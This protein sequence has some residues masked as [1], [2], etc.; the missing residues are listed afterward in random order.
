VD[1][2]G[3]TEPLALLRAPSLSVSRLLG[4]I[5]RILNAWRIFFVAKNPKD[6][7][8]FYEIEKDVMC[9]N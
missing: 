1:P 7:K 8:I 5:L 4:A 9:G 2:L 6:P 3:A